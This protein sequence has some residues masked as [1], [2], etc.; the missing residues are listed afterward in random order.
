MSRRRAEVDCKPLPVVAVSAALV[1]L[2]IAAPAAAA[3]SHVTSLTT[4]G[5][6]ALARGYERVFGTAHGVV[7]GNEGVRGLPAAGL[8][9]GVQ[10]ELIRPAGKA[11]VRLLLVEAENRGSPLLLDALSPDGSASG[12]PALVTYPP[13]V[14][15]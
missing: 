8:S 15:R 1:A 5:H 6:Q 7:S 12:S 3:R 2:V 14:S 4:E 9:Y 11:K 13:S 10:Y